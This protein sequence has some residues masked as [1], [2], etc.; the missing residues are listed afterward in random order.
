MTEINTI[1]AEERQNIVSDNHSDILEPNFTRY[2][3]DQYLNKTFNKF[4]KLIA[5]DAVKKKNSNTL[6]NIQPVV[7][8]YGL[9]KCM[10]LTNL[11]IPRAEVSHKQIIRIYGNLSCRDYPIEL[12]SKLLQWVIT[13]YDYIDT[14]E[15]L[16]CL[17]G[18]LFRYLNMETLRPS[19]CHILY[20]MTTKVHVKRYR[21]NYL[22]NLF[23]SVRSE[24]QL[25]S[26][27]KIYKMYK[28]ELFINHTLDVLP[29]KTTVPFP[30]PLTKMKGLIVSVRKL[31][32]DD[33]TPSIIN[34]EE[35]SLIL[36]EEELFEKEEQIQN[37]KRQK[38]RVN[39]EDMI[40]Y[41]YSTRL[42]SNK[43]DP[44]MITKDLDRQDIPKQINTVL[45]NRTIQHLL[46][47][48][49]NDTVVPRINDVLS[50]RL[51][52]LLHWND[53][54]ASSDSQLKQLLT[55]IL[56]LA[57]FSKVHV[58]AIEV[59]L[60]RYIRSWN[61]MDF[62]YEIFNLL[63]FIKPM[64]FEEI[65][66]YYLRPLY[67]LFCVSNTAWKANLILCYRDWLKNWA[68]LDWKRHSE[69]K[70]NASKN[71]EE[72]DI[73]ELAWLFQGLSFNIEY[74]ETMQQ[75]IYHVD[76]LCV[77]GLVLEED[78]PLIQ[79]AALSFFEFTSSISIQHDVP[80]IVIPAACLVY[81]TFF[82][83]NAMAVSRI[84]GILSHYKASF[85][86]N[87]RKSIDWMEQHDQDY[88]DQFNLYVLDICNCLWRNLAFKIDNGIGTSFS[89]TPDI[90]DKMKETSDEKG[91][92]LQVMFS[93][94]H[95]SAFIGYSKRYMR[96]MEKRYGILE[97]YQDPVN[98]EF[99]KLLKDPNGNTMTIMEYRTKYLDYLKEL[100][101]DGIYE[102]L[103]SSMSSLANRQQ[104]QI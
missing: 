43:F 6:E 64:T 36:R 1:T 35:L 49:S 3:V 75:F 17:Y 54:S 26:L 33:I 87:E 89:L 53:P 93:L 70:K 85:E 83:N 19:L 59:F 28:P 50:Q 62:E 60:M 66:E 29:R 15:K 42:S 9:K 44:T 10:D 51:L 18:V 101:F 76:R 52:D 92:P 84:C 98:T 27:I 103:Y 74:F 102:L 100:G 47:C 65:Y 77:Q 34:E 38:K 13:I 22:V 25:T 73:D 48:Q 5:K 82:S 67:R 104:Q 68:L 20:F 90:I 57:R 86:D 72:T 14:T 8:K 69:R 78:H 99:V 31:W 96:K 23:N 41:E 80:A 24:P 79:H 4:D 88:L 58:P 94:T 11:L 63:T 97:H 55:Q 12:I 30:T 7:E 39:R 21:V 61:G 2:N 56:Q 40:L 95:S 45:E 91:I 71:N 16:D 46:V 32:K 81:R 37:R